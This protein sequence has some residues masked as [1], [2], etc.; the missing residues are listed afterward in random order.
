MSGH[1]KWATIKRKK[2]AADNK[3]GQVFTKLANAIT[4]AA[5]D[6]A[7]PTMNFKLRLVIDKAKAAN[8]PVANIDKSIARGSGQLKGSQIEEVTYE[9]YGPGGVAVIVECATDNKNR[10]NTEVHTALSRHGGHLA[11]PGAVAFQ[12]MPK[13][14]ITIKPVDAEAST[15]NAIDAGAVDV[16]AEEELLHIYTEPKSLH[17]VKQKLEEQ[18]EQIES[19]ELTLIPNQILL[20]GDAEVAQK[21]IGLMDA[22]DELED[23]V[24][25]H[26]NF[27]IPADLL[28][29]S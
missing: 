24:A 26:S 3:R 11:E 29:S 22:L 16:E 27:D 18:G 23:V 12:F 7:D 21:V 8:M 10:T 28:E 14:L 9:G 2:G 4:V 25:T 13:G 15:L 19:A 20:I 5:K 17:A 6:G 1:S